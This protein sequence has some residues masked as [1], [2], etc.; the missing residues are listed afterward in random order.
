MNDPQHIHGLGKVEG[1]L[2]ILIKDGEKA[3]DDRRV[4][5]QRVEKMER[6]QERVERKLDSQG[7][8]IKSVEV[9]IENFAKWRERFIGMM[10]VWT[11]IA[12]GVGSVI[13]YYWQKIIALVTG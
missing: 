7:E 3:R 9:P 4:L 1:M 10:M 8:R 13:T 11:V 6:S 2:A 5:Y 12:G